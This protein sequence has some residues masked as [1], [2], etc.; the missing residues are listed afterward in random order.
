MRVRPAGRP[1]IKGQSGNPGGR[2]KYIATLRE[3]ARAHTADAVQE[4]A[5][6]AVHAKSETA[7]V[8]AIRELLDRGYG[9]PTQFLAADNDAVP[10]SLCSDELRAE[11]LEHFQCLFPEYRLVP[12][13]PLKVISPP[14]E[15]DSRVRL[16][17]SFDS[18]ER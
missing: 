3:L 4:L 18:D 12:S 16:K 14:V 1:F 11:I 5:R 10:E 17:A 7:H 15:T 6:L 2:P 9:R 13:K 8:S